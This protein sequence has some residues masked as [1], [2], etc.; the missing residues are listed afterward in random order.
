VQYVQELLISPRGDKHLGQRITRSA[1]GDMALSCRP[2]HVG[3]VNEGQFRPKLACW[4]GTGR[5]YHT[6]HTTCWSVR[7]CR[8]AVEVTEHKVAQVSLVG[9]GQESESRQ[10][11]NADGGRARSGF[12]WLTIRTS[13]RPL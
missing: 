5:T 1:T 7:I 4:E 12:V 13:G 6:G 8:T 10:G 2:L 11:R 3:V 9:T